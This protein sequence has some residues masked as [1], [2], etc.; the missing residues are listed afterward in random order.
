AGCGAR[1]NGKPLPRGCAS[2]LLTNACTSSLR[3]RCLGP[4]PATL[5]KSTP[6]SRA[7]RRTDG[8]ACTVPLLASTGSGATTT[9]VGFAADGGVAAGGIATGCAGTA[10]CGAGLAAA[11]AVSSIST[12]APSDTLS[13]TLTLISLIVPARGAGTSIVALSDSSVTNGSS[14]FTLSPGLTRTSITGTFL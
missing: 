10:A 13:P 11:P 5:V 14:S 1:L 2:S 3:M 12:T 9:R 4:W 7:K 8:L 6:S